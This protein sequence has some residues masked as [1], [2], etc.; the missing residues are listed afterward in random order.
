MLCPICGM[1]IDDN[2]K[3][4]GGCGALIGA[5]TQPVSMVSNPT[6]AQQMVKEEFIDALYSDPNAGLFIYSGYLQKQI[7]SG[8]TNE[9]IIFK[10]VNVISL[11]RGFIKIHSGGL[12]MTIQPSVPHEFLKILLS[13]YGK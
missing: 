7:S 13:I 4:C 5:V 10:N 12:T 8:E 3:F 9:Y 1:R 11:T 6:V 2:A